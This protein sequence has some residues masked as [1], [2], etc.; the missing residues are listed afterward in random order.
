MSIHNLHKYFLWADICHNPQVFLVE[1]IINK[2]TSL[3]SLMTSKIC[4]FQL[5]LK[6]N[7]NKLDFN[8]LYLFLL[9]ITKLFN[10]AFLYSQN[11]TF[12]IH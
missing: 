2:S 11:F 7:V 9:K 10:F 5:H 1:N 8:S 6:N 3:F 12:D 4:F